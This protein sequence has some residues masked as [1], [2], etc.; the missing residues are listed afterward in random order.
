MQVLPWNLA[1]AAGGY[2]F[3]IP[4]PDV[5]NIAFS[6]VKRLHECKM[7]SNTTMRI[8]TLNEM[9]TRIVDYISQRGRLWGLGGLF[10][11]RYGAEGTG[12]TKHRNTGTSDAAHKTV[13]G[14]LPHF[15]PPDEK[16]FPVDR[17]SKLFLPADA[18]PSKIR[19]ER[20]S[21]RAQS[22]L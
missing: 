17:Q 21:A 16:A 4:I 18:M 20:R 5:G 19:V 22:R 1:T 13:S 15:S 11:H 2:T 7:E 10:R 3:P 8:R 14:V 9:A 12:T 6:V